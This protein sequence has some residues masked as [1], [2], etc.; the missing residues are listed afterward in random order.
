MYFLMYKSVSLAAEPHSSD[1]IILRRLNI[2]LEFKMDNNLLTIQTVEYS[3]EYLQLMENLMLEA[4]E[5]SF[6][7]RQ[8]YYHSDS[9]Y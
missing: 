4:A 9:Q 6:E 8:Y 2:F 3:E 5:S 1:V 7:D